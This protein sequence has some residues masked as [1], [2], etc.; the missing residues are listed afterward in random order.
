MVS[1]MQPVIDWVLGDWRGK[2]P[3]SSEFGPSS[4]MLMLS[5]KIAIFDTVLF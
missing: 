5:A 2:E 4:F 3:L 1:G